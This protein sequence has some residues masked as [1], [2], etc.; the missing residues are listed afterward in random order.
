MVR[1]RQP[2][3]DDLMAIHPKPNDEA[4]S[5]CPRTTVFQE[6]SGFTRSQRPYGRS[7]PATERLLL[8]PDESHRYRR[9][10]DRLS[11]G[12]CGVDVHGAH[13]H[14]PP[15]RS[16]RTSTDSSK[17]IRSRLSTGGSNFQSVGTASQLLVIFGGRRRTRLFGDGS[18]RAVIDNI[19]GMTSRRF[20]PR[21][22]VSARNT[23]DPAAEADLAVQA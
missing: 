16:V 4:P 21:T 20:S 15:H 12:G 6:H 11:T 1:H 19:S 7:E 23:D 18:V 22:Q 3:A 10:D 2:G 8:A 9:A 5:S 13:R 17:G 14:C